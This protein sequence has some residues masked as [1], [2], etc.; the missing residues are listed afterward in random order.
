[1]YIDRG[2]RRHRIEGQ[3]LFATL[4]IGL[5]GL[6]RLIHRTNPFHPKNAVD[7]IPF[8]TGSAD[9]LRTGKRPATEKKGERA[10][11]PRLLGRT[12][13]GTVLI[14]FVSFVKFACAANSTSLKA[15]SPRTF[16]TLVQCWLE[17]GAKPA[18]LRGLK[19]AGCE[20][21]ISV[22]RGTGATT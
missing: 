10:S 6:P 22:S 1:M 7:H 15:G 17:F 18:P 8:R 11:G 14:F 2:G 21:K 4:L 12:N 16:G 13:G 20:A 5:I 3:W 19:L 9:A